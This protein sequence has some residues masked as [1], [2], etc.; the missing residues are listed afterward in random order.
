VISFAPLSNSPASLA[1]PPAREIEAELCRRHFAEFVRHA[2]PVLEPGVELVWNWHLDAICEHLEAVSDGRIQKLIIN[3]PPGHAKSVLVSVLWPVWMWLRDPSWR[4]L[5]LSYANDLALRDNTRARN[6]LESEWFR[7]TFQPTWSLSSDQNVKSRYTNTATGERFAG[8]VGAKLTGFRG[9]CIVIDDPISE[10]DSR[11]ETKREK[12]LQWF[13]KTTTT[14]LNDLENDPVVIIMQRLHE[15]DLTGHLLRDNDDGEWEHLC[16]PSEYDP[17]R[18]SSTSIGWEDPRTEPGELLFPE[19]FPV[20]A[21]EKLKKPTKLG[22]RGFAGQHQQQPSPDEGDIFKREWWQHWQT[23]PDFDAVIQ[24]WDCTF[25]DTK[26]SDYVVGQ[27]WGKKGA[28]YYLIDQVRARMGFAATKAA[29]IAMK[30]R[31][32]QSTKILI[33]DKA[34]GTAIIEMLKAQIPGIIAVNPKGGKEARA[35]AVQGV[36]EAGQVFLPPKSTAWVEGL[37][38]ET[39]SFPNGSH[40]DQVDALTQAL[41]RLANFGYKPRLKFSMAGRRR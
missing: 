38:D 10:P 11:S 3:I 31:Y 30:S 4:V 39:A 15:D 20:T 8:A 35:N 41:M 28:S 29:I 9:D 1:L 17:A 18:H 5:A 12:A 34:N 22:A 40:D 33:E 2:W 21:L 13:G 27:V 36:V 16:L 7:D 23:L 19:R 25:K 6:V 32:P 37:I 26:T 14:R 24:S